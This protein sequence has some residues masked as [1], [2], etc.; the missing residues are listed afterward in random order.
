MGTV[1]Q[2]CAHAALP[3]TML[4]PYETRIRKEEP[5]DLQEAIDLELYVTGDVL[6]PLGLHSGSN[7]MANARGSSG[8][9]RT[10]HNIW[11]SNLASRRSSSMGWNSYYRARE[12]VMRQFGVVSASYNSSARR[13]I[14][15][16]TSSIG[17]FGIPGSVGP[18]ELENLIDVLGLGDAE[19]DEIADE[20]M[21]DSG[22]ER[23]EKGMLTILSPPSGEAARRQ[24]HVPS[25]A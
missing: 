3:I 17:H 11:P 12:K 20:A 6:S 8:D 21:I 10:S 13:S 2:W 25:P 1:S 5:E 16:S 9:Q 22:D 4:S 7:A 15:Q 14:P 23:R 18:G 24:T 19:E